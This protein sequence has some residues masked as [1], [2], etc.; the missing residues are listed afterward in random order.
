MTTGTTVK[1]KTEEEKPKKFEK[2]NEKVEIEVEAEA[3]EEEEE[4]DTAGGD[5]EE[6]G[7]KKKK[8]KKNK[9]KKKKKNNIKNIETFYPDGVYLRLRWNE[10]EQ[11]LQLRENHRCGEEIPSKGYGKRVSL[12]RREESRRDPPQSQTEPPEQI[13]AW[14]NPN[15]NC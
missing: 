4:V 12:E 8:K 14:I 9:N 6:A 5:G 11:E 15:R 10:Y 3:E 2:E 7:E 1:A 13:K